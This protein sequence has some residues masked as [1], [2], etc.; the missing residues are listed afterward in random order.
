MKQWYQVILKNS[1]QSDSFKIS[2]LSI[3]TTVFFSVSL[4]SKVNC[5]LLKDH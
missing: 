4:T 2:W 1:M 5:D 3:E